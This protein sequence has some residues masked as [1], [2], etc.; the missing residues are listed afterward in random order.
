MRKKNALILAY[1]AADTL[2]L[3]N[4]AVVNREKSTRSL[5]RRARGD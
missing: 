1:Q 4:V 5:P 2:V 3:A